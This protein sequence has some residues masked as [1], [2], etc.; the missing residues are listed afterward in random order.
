VDGTTGP[1]LNDYRNVLAAADG[2][3][4][5]IQEGSMPPARP[6]SD[7]DKALFQ[8]WISAGKPNN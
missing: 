8:A 2:S 3:N 6:L 4:R 1:A 7:A 5:S